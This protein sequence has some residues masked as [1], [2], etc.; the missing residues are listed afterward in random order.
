MGVNGGGFMRRGFNYSVG[1]VITL[2]L[3]IGVAAI[4]FGGGFLL[5]NPFT[6]IA[7]L[8]GPFGVYT[9]IYAAV[10]KEG[11]RYFWSLIYLAI[12]A[13]SL[14]HDVVNPIVVGGALLIALAVI[15]V[16][17]YLKVLNVK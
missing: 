13:A 8:S 3:S 9:L 1:A 4:V 17:A 2:A 12:A 11:N 6:F 5:F 10:S 14:F 16:L 7:W 15:G